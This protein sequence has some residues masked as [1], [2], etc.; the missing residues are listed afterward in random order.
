MQNSKMFPST[1]STTAFHPQDSAV[2]ELVEATT[3]IGLF[4]ADVSML[5]QAQRPLQQILTTILSKKLSKKYKK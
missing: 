1:S 5:R 4:S 3:S 2:A